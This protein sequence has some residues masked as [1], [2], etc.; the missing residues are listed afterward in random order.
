[1]SPAAELRLVGIRTRLYSGSNFDQYEAKHP[2]EESGIFTKAHTLKLG[3]ICLLFYTKCL[4]LGFQD[5]PSP[6]PSPFLSLSLA[7]SP[8]IAPASLLCGVVWI[9]SACR[10]PPSPP[11]L[12]ARGK[13]LCF[14]SN[15]TRHYHRLSQQGDEGGGAARKGPSGSFSS[16]TRKT[17]VVSRRP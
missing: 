2:R 1:M 9:S 15:D 7:S 6:S 10:S 13:A 8:Q 12:K 5:V 3:Y 4:A 11:C 14:V 16:R 17:L